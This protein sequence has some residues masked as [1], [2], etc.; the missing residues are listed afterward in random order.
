MVK[1]PYLDE[2]T[3]KIAARMLA[4]PPKRHEDMKLGKKRQLAKPRETKRAK[5]V[6]NQS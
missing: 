5:T 3:R 4:M 2:P 6:D 1:K